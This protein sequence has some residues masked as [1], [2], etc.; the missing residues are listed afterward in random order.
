M[1]SKLT[2]EEKVACAKLMQGYLGGRVLDPISAGV[3]HPLKFRECLRILKMMVLDHYTREEAE[4]HAGK[5]N[6]RQGQGQGRTG[7]ISNGAN[8]QKSNE[9]KEGPPW[10][11]GGTIRTEAWGENTQKSRPQSSDSRQQNVQ[12]D[13][14]QQQQSIA[15]GQ[16]ARSESP[17]RSRSVANEDVGAVDTESRSRTGQW[18]RASSASSAARRG[19]LLKQEEGEE[20]LKKYGK[21]AVKFSHSIAYNNV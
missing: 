1:E 2:D 18:S 19:Y 13:R 7:G 5:Q 10:I 6:V 3:T 14:Q 4:K 9:T 16:R 12:N 21:S 17:T 8:V 15:N 11:P 20:F